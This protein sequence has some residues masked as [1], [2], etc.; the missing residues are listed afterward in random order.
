MQRNNS[1]NT[2]RV[3]T[4]AD[5]KKVHP[6]ANQNYVKSPGIKAHKLKHRNLIPPCNGEPP[7]YLNY[8]AI[9]FVK[10]EKQKEK[11]KR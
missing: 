2:V 9:Q 7:N 8:F 4:I 11:Q 6:K 10:K 5:T 3:V 1:D